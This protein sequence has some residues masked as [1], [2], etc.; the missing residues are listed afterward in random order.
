MKTG[1]FR[2]TDDGGAE[3]LC[4]GYVPAKSAEFEA[5]WTSEA[6]LVART[7]RFSLLLFLA[8][9]LWS[10]FGKPPVTLRTR[11]GRALRW[12]QHSQLR[13]STVFL[14]ID[15]NYGPGEE[16]LLWET[17]VFG[18]R[19]ESQERHASLESA[20]LCHAFTCAKVFRFPWFRPETEYGECVSRFRAHRAKKQFLETLSS[21]K[22]A[23]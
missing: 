22:G 9:R 18:W 3:L 21:S 23:V 7:A 19:K 10:Y 1:Y 2:M 12:I 5:L 17:M 8:E 14:V 20:L 4:A 13:V 15:H 16:P 11:W 6:R